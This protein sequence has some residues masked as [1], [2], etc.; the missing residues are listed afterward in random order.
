MKFTFKGKEKLFGYGAA[1][2]V[3]AVLVM[4]FFFFGMFSSLKQ[5]EQKTKI[6]EA[7]LK[8]DLAIQGSKDELTNDYNKYLPYLKISQAPQRQ[9]IED[10]LKE[11]ERIAKE[12]RATVINLSPQATAEQSKE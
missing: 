5:L 12:S 7:R 10:L 3:A 8:E 6:E 11:T 9:I 1:G 4:R 2:L